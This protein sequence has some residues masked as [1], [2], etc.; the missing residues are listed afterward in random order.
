MATLKNIAERVGKSV[1]TV[2]RAL[3]GYDDVSP[4]TKMLVRK[5]AEEIGYTPNIIAQRLQK[6]TTDTI[7]FVIPTYGPRFTD[8]FFTEFLAG[9]G[10]TAAKLGFDLLVSTHPISEEEMRSYQNKVQS[11]RVDGFILVRTRRDDARIQYL[12]N[13][14]FPFVAFGRTEGDCPFPYVDVD[15]RY[16]MKMIADHLVKLGHRKIAYI[17][18]PNYLMFANER[19]AGFKEALKEHDLDLSSSMCK[20][21]DLTQK[22]GLEQTEALLDY[23][24]PPTAIVTCNDLMA[25]G[26]IRTA[27][28]RGLQIGE[29]LAVI[30]YDDIPQA[31][32]NLPSLTTIHQPIYQIGSK[33]CNMLICLLKGEVLVDQ[34]IIMKP[35]LIIRESCGGHQLN[36]LEKEAK[37]KREE[38]KHPLTNQKE[39]KGI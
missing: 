3:H 15:N 13:I 38:R 25:L 33:V 14:N 34:K 36:V 5:V 23:P 12:C 29:D 30:G 31:E 4:E 7:G 26:V 37:R 10:N 2:S 16:A 21:G 39:L 19:L 1:T 6:K 35:T 8:P 24:D 11:Y 9:I 28:K 20:V 22:S 27:Q 18:A 32:H 17:G